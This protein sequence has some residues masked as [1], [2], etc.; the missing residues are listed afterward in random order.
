MCLQVTSG[1]A[2]KDQDQLC[3]I[4]LCGNKSKYRVKGVLWAK[5]PSGSTV[6]WPWAELKLLDYY[7]GQAEERKLWIL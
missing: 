2:K 3:G 4:T 7:V 1:Q 6:S 5:A